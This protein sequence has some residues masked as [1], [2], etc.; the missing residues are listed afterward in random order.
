MNIAEDAITMM[1]IKIL[2]NRFFCLIDNY[3]GYGILST[4]TTNLELS[5]ISQDNLLNFLS[6][7]PKSFLSF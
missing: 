4:L 7:L 6:A 1:S 2:I 3:A 5:S